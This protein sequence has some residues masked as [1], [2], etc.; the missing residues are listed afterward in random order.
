MSHNKSTRAQKEYVRAVIHQLSLQRLSDTEIS[1]YLAEKGIVLARC[2][3]NGIKKQIEKQ[4]E[5]WYIELKQSRYKYIATY[6][7]RLDSLLSYQKLLHDMISSIKKEEIKIRAIN[8]LT[9]IEMNIFNLWKQLP[10]LDIVSTTKQE[11]QQPERQQEEEDP[12]VCSIEDIN[13]VEEIPEEDKRLWH[14]WEQCDHCKRWWRGRELLDYHMKRT[15]CG[16]AIVVVEAAAT[17]GDSSIT[18]TQDEEDGEG[19][20]GNKLQCPTCKKSFYNNFELSVH[21]CI[22][23]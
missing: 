5:K 4:A 13:G 20:G 8:E 22:A 7:E 19:E 6:K 14:N 9:N 21:Q 12:P 18:E 1:D 23:T 2:S 16:S 15:K 11:Q 10:E 17:T 3:V